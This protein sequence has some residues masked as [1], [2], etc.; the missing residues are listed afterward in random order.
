VLVTGVGYRIAF[1]RGTPLF[2]KAFLIPPAGAVDA[3]L[4]AGSAIFGI[5]WGL[6]GFCPGPAVVA[7][8]LGATPAVVFV[9][10]MLAGM[11]LARQLNANRAAPAL[12]IARQTN[13]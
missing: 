6:V 10:A 13:S 2:D 11:A 9:A 12:T 5:G 4:L 7:L 3:R 8:G 1:A